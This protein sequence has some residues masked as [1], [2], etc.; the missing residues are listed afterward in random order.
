MCACSLHRGDYRPAY[1]TICSTFT[2]NPSPGC[3]TFR[4]SRLFL[5]AQKDLIPEEAGLLKAFRRSMQR[6]HI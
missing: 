1:H 3:C 4:I 6:K 5:I 2:A